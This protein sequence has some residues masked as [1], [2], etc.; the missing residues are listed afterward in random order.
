MC[1]LLNLSNFSSVTLN[2][3]GNMLLKS[4]LDGFDSL[5]WNHIGSFLHR[6]LDNISRPCTTFYMLKY[7]VCIMVWS[8]VGILAINKYCV[9]QTQVLRLTL[10]KNVWMCFT[11][12]KI[13]CVIKQLLLRDWVVNLQ[14]ILREGM[15]QLT[16]YLR[17]TLWVTMMVLSSVRSL[18]IW[19]LFS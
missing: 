6:F 11:N 9:S 19:H 1:R 15:L 16:F 2:V 7:W 4:H 3:D 5:I 8:C 17:M 12:M 18:L 14:H 10:F 13:W